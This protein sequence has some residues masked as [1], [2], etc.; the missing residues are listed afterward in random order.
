MANLSKRF[1]NL[2]A[3]TIH[4][5]SLVWESSRAWTILSLVIVLLQG[6]TPVL[7]FFFLGRIIDTV[8]AVVQDSASLE[9]LL[10]YIALFGLVNLFDAVLNSVYTVVREA[11]VLTLGDHVT[12]MIHAKSIALD[13]EFYENAEYHD[14]LHRAQREAPSRPPMIVDNLTSAMRSAV[15]LIG[16]IGLLYSLQPLTP[17]ILVIGVLPVVVI[18]I[19]YSQVVYNWRL[20]TTQSERRGFYLSQVL[21]NA[22]FASEIRLF[23]N[24]QLFIERYRQLRDRLRKERLGITIQRA[25]ADVLTQVLTIAA[26]FAAIWLVTQNALSQAITI[27]QFVV[28]LQ[29]FQSGQSAMKVLMGTLSSL[30]EN[31]LFLRDYFKFMELEG[32]MDVP[33]HPVPVP[34]PIKKGFR[35]ENVAFQYSAGNREVLKEIN[36]EIRAGEIVALVGDNGAGKTTLIKLLCRLYD[37]TKG[38][39]TLDGHDLRDYDPVELRRAITV[40]FQNFNVYQFSALENIW[41]GDTSAPPNFDD[42]VTAAQKSGAAEVIERLPQQYETQLGLLFDGGQE[43]SY[44]QWQKIALARAFLRNAQMIILDEPTSAL[45]VITEHEIFERFHKIIAG[46]SAILISHRLSTVRMAD[47][48][49]V[50]DQGEIVENG[51]HDEL[52]ALGGRYAELY[53]MQ[54]KF[55]VQ[56]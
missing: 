45:D 43:L 37:P 49:M 52:I 54:S 23:N 56:N 35:F 29:A 33:A 1:G 28:V 50:L 42:I 4:A 2:S 18:R 39:I 10:P 47:R 8:T 36:F 19:Y 51:S 24:G 17:V 25:R 41:I 44:G 55:Y 46:R 13:L 3:S 48:I 16:I 11:Q 20:R 27:G 53:A 21:T 32:G 5:L 14:T 15:T 26:L 22:I 9:T 34:E 30:Y 6:S 40:L 38:R 12:N 31:N 7:L